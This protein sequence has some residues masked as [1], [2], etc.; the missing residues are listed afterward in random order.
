MLLCSLWEPVTKE[1]SA[2]KTVPFSSLSGAFFQ[3][4]AGLELSCPL[5]RIEDA[6]AAVREAPKVLEGAPFGCGDQGSK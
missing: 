2:T 4:A 6:S 1:T 3:R 5:P